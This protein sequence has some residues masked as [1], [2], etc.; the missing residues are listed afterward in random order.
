MTKALELTPKII[1]SI[2]WDA[3]NASMRACGRTVWNLDDVEAAQKVETPL[4]RTY[5]TLK[6]FDL[7]VIDKIMGINQ[8]A[9]NV[10]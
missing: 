1:N 6:G 3:A 5:Y 10:A 4:W 8:E 2:G 7:S 9:S